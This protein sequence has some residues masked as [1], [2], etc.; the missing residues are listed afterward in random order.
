MMQLSSLEYLEL[1]DLND[2]QQNHI[3]NLEL[4]HQSRCEA[5]KAQCD[6]QGKFLPIQCDEDQCWCV[7]EAGNQLPH[8]NA[9]KK[10][11]KMCR[12]FRECRKVLFL[13]KSNLVTTPIEFVDVTIGFKGEYDDVS[14]IPIVN[15]IKMLLSNLKGTIKNNEVMAKITSDV[16]Y[17]KLQLIGNNKVDVAFLLEQMVNFDNLIR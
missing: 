11:E 12:K 9:F 17:I 1:D 4:V 3:S 5:L 16:L 6:G 10:G 14:A 2:E 8:S 13:I 7:D 15:K